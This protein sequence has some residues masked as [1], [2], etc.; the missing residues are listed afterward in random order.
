MRRRGARQLHQG[1][2]LFLRCESFAEQTLE[3]FAG[4]LQGQFI[5]VA[6]THS[7]TLNRRRKAPG[8]RWA[9]WK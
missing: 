9:R 1:G 3:Q 5:K 7:G 8:V 6:H 4:S 2:D